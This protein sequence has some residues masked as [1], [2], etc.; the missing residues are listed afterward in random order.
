[1][2]FFTWDSKRVKPNFAWPRLHHARKLLELFFCVEA[3]IGRA[4]F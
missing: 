1:M 4:R 2:H 3:E